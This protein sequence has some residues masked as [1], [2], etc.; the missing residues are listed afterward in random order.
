MLSKLKSRVKKS[1]GN[2]IE[3]SN[4][5]GDQIT[6]FVGYIENPNAKNSYY[7]CKKTRTTFDARP[8]LCV[9]SV[10][11]RKTQIGQAAT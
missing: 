5:G 10:N 11:I 1:R 3:W 6:H 8:S 2:D 4:L 7:N 9:S